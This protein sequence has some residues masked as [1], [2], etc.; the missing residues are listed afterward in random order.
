MA[1]WKTD[2]I[3]RSI[4]RQIAGDIGGAE[5]HVRLST[6][7][8]DIVLQALAP[9]RGATAGVEE[10]IA[11]CLGGLVNQQPRMHGGRW[12]VTD[13]NGKL[14]PELF[15]DE[16]A[17]HEHLKNLRVA[18]IL[19][20]LTGSLGEGKAA[21]LIEAV[22]GIDHDYMTSENHHPGYVLIPTG[23]FESIRAAIRSLSDGEGAK[24]A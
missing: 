9:D 15:D 6:T 11:K 20:A 18:N 19:A 23:R 13:H 7:D 3:R 5:H 17:A 24:D 22:T 16:D 12:Y 10:R 4:I 14:C 1:D 8:W 21:A 2:D